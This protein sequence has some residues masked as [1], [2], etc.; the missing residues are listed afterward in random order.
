MPFSPI[1]I[2]VY[3]PYLCGRETEYV[4]QCLASSWISKGD[5]NGR[6]ERQF[7]EFLGDCHAT[8]VSNG[9]TALHLALLAL[10]IGPGDEVIVPTLTYI[11]SVNMIAHSGATPVLV[12]STVSSWQMDPEDVKRK[13]TSRTR[14]V[15]AVHLY[16]QSCEMTALENICR[17]NG[18]WLIEDCAEA[19]GSSYRGRNVGTFGDIATFSFF[20]NKT[21]TT[22]E[23]GMVVSRDPKLLQKAIHLKGQAVSP[24]RE[25]WHDALGFNYRMNNICAAIGLAQMESATEILKKKRQIAGWYREMLRGQPL[26]LHEEAEGTHHSFWLCSALAENERTRDDLRAAIRNEGIETRPVFHPAHTMPVFSSTL[27]FPVAE[28]ISRRGFSLPSYPAL[29]EDLVGHVCR[30]IRDFFDGQVDVPY[31]APQ[32]SAAPASR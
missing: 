23:G 5:F 25:Y 8:S 28:D 32:A 1:T 9:T 26:E 11:A 3:Q 20:G 6:F 14:A 10:G 22:G 19:F 27:P 21:I 24:S 4:N 30:C 15:L 29:T 7:E 13:I 2:P 18:L 31:H 17:E 16:G 12:D